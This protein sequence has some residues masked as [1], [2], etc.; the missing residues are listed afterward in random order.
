VLGVDIAD[1]AREDGFGSH[2]RRSVLRQKQQLVAPL[3][4]MDPVVLLQCVVRG[5]Q[6]DEVV[7]DLLSDAPSLLC[8]FVKPLL[9]SV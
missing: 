7:R 2:L 8:L 5:G 1:C 6:P 9:S 4:A 3:V